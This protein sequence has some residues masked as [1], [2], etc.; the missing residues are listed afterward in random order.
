MASKMSDH[1]FG[2]CDGHHETVDLK[3]RK[4]G[5]A[6]SYARRVAASRELPALAAGTL[7]AASDQPKGNP[8]SDNLWAR[9]SDKLS[10]LVGFGGRNA[11]YE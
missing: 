8:T 2:R 1:D 9:C 3:L 6:F 10:I 7:N 5:P 4:A 11:K